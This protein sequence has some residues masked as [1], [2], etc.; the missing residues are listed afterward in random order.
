M[1][2]QLGKDEFDYEVSADWGELPD[3]WKLGDVAA[4]AI[5]RADRVYVFHRGTH[6]LIVFDRHGKFLSSWGDDIFNQP[7][8]LHIGSDDMI[9]CTDTGDHTV[10]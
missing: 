7:H 8:G 3:G 1:P 9:Y 10:R 4:V 5:D 2:T 6:P